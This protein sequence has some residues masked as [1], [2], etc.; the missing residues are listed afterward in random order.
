[1]MQ[2]V[3]VKVITWMGRGPAVFICGCSFHEF[4]IRGFVLF[5]S[6]SLPLTFLIVI[7]DSVAGGRKQEGRR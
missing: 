3:T 2:S 5:L 1:M 7:L 4:R 6:H